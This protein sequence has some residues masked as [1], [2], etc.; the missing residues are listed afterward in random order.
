MIMS[1]FGTKRTCRFALHMSAFDPK[2]TSVPQS[3][4]LA[5]TNSVLVSR[6]RPRRPNKNDALKCVRADGVAGHALAKMCNDTQYGRHHDGC[7]EHKNRNN[8]PGHTANM[9]RFGLIG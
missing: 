9:Q 1:A 2:R 5:S 7:S 4:G 8:K 3:N 6:Y